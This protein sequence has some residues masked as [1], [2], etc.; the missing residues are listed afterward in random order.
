MLWRKLILKEQILGI[1]FFGH[2]FQ[3]HLESYHFSYDHKWVK[4]ACVN[5]NELL[6]LIIAILI[7]EFKTRDHCVLFFPL[8]V[9]YSLAETK[10]FVEDAGS[11]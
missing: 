11:V 6:H 9:K 8:E 7:S 2:D 4:L 1:N 10:S 5:S 3:F